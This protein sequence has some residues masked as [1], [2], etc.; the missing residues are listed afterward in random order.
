MATTHATSARNAICNAVTA[1]LNGGSANAAGIFRFRTNANAI[2]SNNALANPAF[3]NGS[4]GTAQS[5]AVSADTNATGGVISSATLEDRDRNV[6]LT[7][8]DIRTT[9]GGDM[10]GNNLTV[11]S[12][13]TVQILSLS[14]VAPQ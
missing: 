5:N 14:Y 12:G 8:N 6:I 7:A 3:Q 13:A 11:G 9:A 2:V 1:L 10:Q 4:G